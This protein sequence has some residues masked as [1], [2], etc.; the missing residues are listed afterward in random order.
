MQG[1]SE[2]DA[3]E[4][5]RGDKFFKEALGIMLLPTSP[6]LR[7]RFDAQGAAM[8][9]LVPGMIERLLSGQLFLGASAATAAGQVR[10]G[11]STTGNP[12][13]QRLSCSRSGIASLI[14]E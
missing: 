13:A 5:Y 3:I 1:K 9:E 4:R 8:F 14:A 7:Q 6:T 10:T 12:F 2:C 11:T